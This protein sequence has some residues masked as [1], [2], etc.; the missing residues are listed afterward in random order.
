MYVLFMVYV[1][2][3]PYSAVELSG[4]LLGEFLLANVSSGMHYL[5]GGYF[6]L[7]EG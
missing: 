6:H 5:T 3:T 4:A 7:L 1:Q 2:R